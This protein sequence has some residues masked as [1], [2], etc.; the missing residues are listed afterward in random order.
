MKAPAMSLTTRLDSAINAAIATRIVGCVI[1][2]R[3]E[4]REV[5]AR[6]AGFADRE[7]GR[8]MTR[9]AIFRLASVTKPIVATATL[10]MCD[11]GLLRLDDPVTKFLPDFTPKTQDGAVVPILISHLLTHTSGISYDVPPDVSFGIG[12]PILSMEENLRR[13]AKVPLNFKPG[14]AWEYGMSID[15]L[16]AVI[17][18]VNGTDVEGALAKYVCE[19]LGMQDTHFH[20]S[21]HTRLAAVYADGMPP[22][23]YGDPGT[24]LDP[25][26]AAITLSP[27]RI[28][29]KGTF[30]SGGGGMGGTADDVMTLLETYNGAPPIL[31]P[32]TIR[33]ALSNQIGDVPRRA[34]DAGKRFGFIGAV[35]ADP[36]AATTPG[37]AGTVDW[38]GVW[39]HHWLLDPVNRITVVCCTNTAV[40]GCMGKFRDEV[41]AAVYGKS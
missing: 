28:F 26:G 30:Q 39:G 15:V 36:H 2:V 6:A 18:A 17:A 27:S 12:G 10:R 11:L 16:G 40:E 7:A 21:D 29:S 37:P 23:V 3:Q 8:P 5:Y 32:E 22:T 33:A 38:G 24:V 13:L 14:S 19:P 4:N 9:D 31:R 1:L 20:V 41:R 35:L 25:D 34:K